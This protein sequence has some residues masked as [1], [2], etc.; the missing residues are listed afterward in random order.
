MLEGVPWTIAAAGTVAADGEYGQ[1]L[2]T[3]DFALDLTAW[4][5]S[6]VFVQTSA[7]Q[8]EA[9]LAVDQDEWREEIPQIQEW[10]AKIGTD[11]VPAMLMTELDGLRAR[12]GVL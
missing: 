10:F 5:R 7:E 12:L 4:P 6:E 9:A 3:P 11:K 2:T 1:K 8:L